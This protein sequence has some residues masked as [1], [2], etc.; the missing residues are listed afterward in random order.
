MLSAL[1]VIILMQLNYY[2][3]F[4][5]W[6]QLCIEYEYLEVCCDTVTYIYIAS[7]HEV[8]LYH[9]DV[10]CFNWQ[11]SLYTSVC[12]CCCFLNSPCIYVYTNIAT[13]YV[14][15][16]SVS[17]WKPYLYFNIKYT[18]C[19]GNFKFYT[20]MYLLAHDF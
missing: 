17:I 11:L 1:S 20:M 14:T 8:W 3:L 13:H 9:I 7:A 4:S 12:V 2:A 18:I 10:I 15:M 6:L 5:A 19:H 16:F